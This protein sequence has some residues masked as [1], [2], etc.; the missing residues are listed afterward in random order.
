VEQRWCG[1]KIYTLSTDITDK[2]QDKVKKTIADMIDNEELP[3][4]AN[5]LIAT[6]PRSSNFY[7]LPK[8]GP[9]YL[10]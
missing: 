1:A 8:K 5:N 9:L 6:S 2:I 3:T 7:L 4:T 10:Q